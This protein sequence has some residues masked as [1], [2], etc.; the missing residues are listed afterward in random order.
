MPLLTVMS[1][2]IMCNVIL[3]NFMLRD[4]Y[5]FLYILPLLFY[6]IRMQIRF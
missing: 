1:R 3:Y 6:V 5:V 4:I 2:V